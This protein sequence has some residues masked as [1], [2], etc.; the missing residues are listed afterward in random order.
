MKEDV[1]SS[2]EIFQKKLNKLLVEE[3]VGIVIID[4]RLSYVWPNITTLFEGKSLQEKKIHSTGGI[5]I[6]GNEHLGLPMD[7][8]TVWET[9]KLYLNKT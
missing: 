7:S 4:G 5:G 6:T 8:P 3:R 2:L 1:M 9:E